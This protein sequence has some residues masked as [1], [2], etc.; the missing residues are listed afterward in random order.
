MGGRLPSESAADLPRNTHIIATG[1]LAACGSGAGP[2]TTP[3][4]T[5]TPTPAAITSARVPAF[6]SY[7]AVLHVHLAAPAAAN[8]TG[9]VS[10][11]PFVMQNVTVG[12]QPTWL[13]QYNITE[14]TQDFDL[15]V[16]FADAGLKTLPTQATISVQY[17]GF[18]PQDVAHAYQFDKDGT[19]A[20]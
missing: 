5:P 4:P 15:R 10:Q 19:S 8:T 13:S 9:N 18:A 7:S 14:G 11:L 3:A 1:L 20:E 17:P 12:G 16:N 6:V 2:A